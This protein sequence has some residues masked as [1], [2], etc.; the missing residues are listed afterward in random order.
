MLFVT[1]FYKIQTFSKIISEKMIGFTWE[2]LERKILLK[3]T[4]ILYLSNLHV[5]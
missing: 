2:L 4:I 5:T 3:I 1:D